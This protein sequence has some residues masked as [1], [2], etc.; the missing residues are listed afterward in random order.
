MAGPCRLDR[1]EPGTLRNYKMHI[2]LHI[3]PFIGGVKLSK[4][5]RPAVEAFKDKLL[6]TRSRIMVVKVMVSLKS[7]LSDAQRR[8]LV[9]QNMATGTKVTLAGRHERRVKVPTKDEIRAILAKTS[10]LWPATSPWRPFVLVAL[11]AG[12]RPSEFEG[13]VWGCVDFEKKLI[14]VRQRADYRNTMGN[15]K[16]K[17]GTRDVSLAPM[18]L[19]ALRQWRLACPKTDPDALVFPAKRGG[20]IGIAEPHRIWNRL[21]QALDMPRLSYRF[22]DLRHVAASLFIEQGCRRKRCRRLW[23]IAPSR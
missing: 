14:R 6:E 23:A 2:S 5:T 13:L 16:S 1:L 11:F 7:L 17:A 21:L 18:A 12:L 4:L 19:N 22:Y 3:V 15:P 10:E 9:A 20:L 8:G